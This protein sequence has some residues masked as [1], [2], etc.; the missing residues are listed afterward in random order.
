MNETVPG[1]EPDEREYYSA[2][3]SEFIRRRGTPFLLSPKD[4]QLIRQWRRAGIPHEDVVAG[5]DEAFARRAQRGA[6]AKI[7]SLSYC[8]GA[9]LEAWEARARARVGKARPAEEGS[10]D[11]GQ[12]LEEIRRELVLF[13]ERDRRVV[14]AAD[15]ALASLG[16]LARASRSAETIDAALARIE[17]RLLAEIKEAIDP[18]EVERI[19]EECRRLLGAEA[20]SMEEAAARRTLSA[21]GRRKIRERFEVPRL[22][23]LR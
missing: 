13:R 5:I 1:A 23:L 16:R 9:V 12:V 19:D 18:D 3:E 22:T 10:I 8:E 6:L 14:A 7:N 4:F 11:P 20:D 2:V 17:R 15:R 21:L